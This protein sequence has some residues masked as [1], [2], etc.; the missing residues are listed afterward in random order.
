MSP[1][2][3]ASPLLDALRS[4]QRTTNKEFENIHG[5]MT[6]ILSPRRSQQTTEMHKLANPSSM[7]T[8]KLGIHPT[9]DVNDL[10][11]NRGIHSPTKLPSRR[12]PDYPPP[13]EMTLTPNTV[14][15]HSIFN[16]SSTNTTPRHSQSSDDNDQLA[17]DQEPELEQSDTP[18]PPGND[19]TRLGY[20]EHVSP[21]PSPRQ[22][23]G[24]ARRPPLSPEPFG[25]SPSHR[26]IIDTSPYRQSI[27][28]S[29]GSLRETP[30]PPLSRP[31]LYTNPAS[32]SARLHD[33]LLDESRRLDQL[34][35][36]ILAI[37]QHIPETPSYPTS[38]C[39]VS[40]EPVSVTAST[41][42][43]PTAQKIPQPHLPFLFTS[44]LTTQPNRDQATPTSVTFKTTT[45][46]RCHCQLAITRVLFSQPHEAPA[47]ATF[48][49][50]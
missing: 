6:S 14:R 7:K 28:S 30:P 41:F 25:R 42:F 36:D 24:Y 17:Q 21:L 12:I 37:K 47:H 49:S 5:Y 40:F 35:K 13:R 3:T 43:H 20:S 50:G 23:L 16:N 46:I 4:V 44:S 15:S 2:N 18:K 34:Q 45:G 29:P 31:S 19:K 8:P 1:S 39:N 22:P 48:F 33:R 27:T 32:P 9:M 10:E 38:P 26:R 11:I